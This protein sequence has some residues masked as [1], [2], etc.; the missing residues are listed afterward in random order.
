[1][2]GLPA[3]VHPSAAQECPT[4]AA[5]RPLTPPSP[6]PSAL[7]PA[8]PPFPPRPPTVTSPLF[9]YQAVFTQQPSA[10]QILSSCSCFVWTITLI[11]LVKY[12]GI[13]LRFD[14]NGEGER[15][16]A[17]QGRGRGETAALNRQAA[18]AAAG[19]EQA[20]LAA[21][22]SCVLPAPAPCQPPACSGLTARPSSF[23]PPSPPPIAG[24]TFALYSLICR[25]AGFGP[26]G[27]AASADLTIKGTAAVVIG[28]MPETLQRGHWWSLQVPR[29]GEA[30]RRWYKNSRAAQVSLLIVVMLATAMVIGDGFLTPSISGERGAR[31]GSRA[32][33]VC[34]PG[35]HVDTGLCA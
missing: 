32:A 12:V 1:V 14:D 2:R 3:R 11:V 5:R 26:F 17:Q 8:P 7:T 24:G 6:P 21:A 22:R 29:S 28:K 10:E 15:P 33:A 13:I 30:W 9:S 25:A 16:E 35:Q 34:S 23:H 18:L 19:D 20:A 31:V 27:E 4:K